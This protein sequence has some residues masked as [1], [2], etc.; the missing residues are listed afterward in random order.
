MVKEEEEKVI[1]NVCILIYNVGFIRL[2]FHKDKFKS[3]PVQ[4]QEQAVVYLAI[5][6]TLVFWQI[7]M[8]YVPAKY[9]G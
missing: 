1:D 8:Y 2:Y 3:T 9:F 7:Q 6:N 5:S 4:F